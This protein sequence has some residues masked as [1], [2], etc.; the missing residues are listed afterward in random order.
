MA[1]NEDCRHY[2][3]QTVGGRGERIE[4][5]R[6]GANDSLPFACP[7]GCLFY[8]RRGVSNAGWVQP[9]KDPGR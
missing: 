3:M 1:V 8:E 7:Q 5:C 6:M 4:R 9:P 2:I